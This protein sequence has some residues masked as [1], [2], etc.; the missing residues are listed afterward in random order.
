MEEL[1]V[2]GQRVIKRFGPLYEVCQRFDI[3]YLLTYLLHTFWYWIFPGFR[4]ALREQ[5]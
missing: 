5:N 2:R 3:L 4:Q 1:S